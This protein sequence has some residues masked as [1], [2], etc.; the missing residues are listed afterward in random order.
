MSNQCE[1]CPE[2]ECQTALIDS[3]GFVITTIIAN[4]DDDFTPLKEIYDFETTVECCGLLWVSTGDKYDA[5]T[6]T[7][8]DKYY[9]PAI[10][11]N[12][13]GKFI[14]AKDVK[15]ENHP[16]Y[17]A[18]EPTPEPTVA[19]VAEQKLAALGLTKEDIQALL[20]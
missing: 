19:E 9:F 1:N 15:M 20:A 6:N 3:E 2:L 11:K 17:V 14:A 5:E 12:E 18:P 10:I 8:T 4:H 7:F 16:D 13:N